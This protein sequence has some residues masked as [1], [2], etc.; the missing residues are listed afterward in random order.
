M[1]EKVILQ[2][3]QNGRGTQ[4]NRLST[5]GVTGKITLWIITANTSH[6]LAVDIQGWHC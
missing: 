3:G 1:N 4:D 2:L 6:S 5:G